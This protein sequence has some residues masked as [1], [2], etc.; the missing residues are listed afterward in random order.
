MSA[1]V[2]HQG[3]LLSLQD[4]IVLASLNKQKILSTSSQIYIT[5]TTRVKEKLER[6]HAEKLFKMQYIWILEL[7]INR[8]F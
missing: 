1:F 6:Q 7:V 2:A 4:M 3:K 5:I 8:D